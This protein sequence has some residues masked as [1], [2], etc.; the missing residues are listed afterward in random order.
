MVSEGRGR[1]AW[2]RL[3]RDQ[4]VRAGR[5]GLRPEKPRDVRRKLEPLVF[6]AVS[7]TPPEEIAAYLETCLPVFERRDT[8]RQAQ[9]SAL[10]LLSH[11]QRKNGETIEAA[12]PGATQQ[13]VWDFLVRSPGLPKN[14]T[15][16]A[17]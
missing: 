17:C 5:F 15:A 8:W 16:A 3:W 12:V 7:L 1:E 13:G 10:G 2:Q 11:L 4:Q 9:S 6:G 14:S